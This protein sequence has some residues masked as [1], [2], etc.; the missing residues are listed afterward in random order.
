MVKGMD[1]T[2][3]ILEYQDEIVYTIKSL[4]KKV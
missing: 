4:Y 3:L 1:I 2:V